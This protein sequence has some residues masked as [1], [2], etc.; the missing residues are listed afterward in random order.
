MLTEMNRAFGFF[1]L[2]FKG[3]F[4][5]G[6]FSNWM[7]KPLRDAINDFQQ[8]SNFFKFEIETFNQSHKSKITNWL[9]NFLLIAIIIYQF[10]FYK[11]VYIFDVSFWKINF[12][13][14]FIIMKLIKKYKTDGK[15]IEKWTIEWRK[16]IHNSRE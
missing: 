1:L 15:A 6:F 3:F 13:L 14:A 5:C 2:I 11:N 7:M 10:W 4:N 8:W 12:L 9:V 16:H